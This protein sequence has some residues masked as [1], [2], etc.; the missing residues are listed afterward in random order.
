MMLRIIGRVTYRVRRRHIADR[1][2]ERYKGIASRLA[3]YLASRW[4]EGDTK[5]LERSS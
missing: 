2:I 3:I 1:M 4:R 5:I